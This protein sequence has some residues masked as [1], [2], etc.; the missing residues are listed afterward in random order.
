MVDQNSQFYAILTNVGA[1]KQA[2]ADVLG[3]PWKITQMGVGDANGSDPTPNATQT[4]LINEWR[5][6]PL[7]QLK[8]D[9]KN[10]AIIVAE[11]V[12]PADVGGKW[13]REIALYDADGDMIAVAN[14]APTYKPLLSQG[15]GR[16][17]VVRMSL[18]VSSSSNVQLK[19]DPSV[20]LS[21]R[22]FV[23]E[24]LARQDFKHSVLVA[25]TASITLSGLQTVD[26]VPLPA[27]ARVLVKNQVAAKD[28]GLFTVVAS[29]PWTRCVDADNSAKVTS[30]LFVL[31]EKGTANGDS[32]WQLV[33]DDPINVGVTPLAFE[34]A[35][36]RTGVAAG[37]YRSVQV[38]KYGRV[39][40]A[41]N[42]TTVAGYGLTDVFTKS[43]T[44]N[45][46]EIAQAISTAVSA[47]IDSAPG[48]LD[49]LKELA[50]ALGNDPN[51]ATTMLN[52]LA[53]KA[54]LSGAAFTGSIATTGSLTVGTSLELGRTD[55]VASVA[56][57][58]LH[59]GATPTDYDARIS[60]FGGNGTAG[61]GDITFTGK[62]LSFA[63]L[64]TAPAHLVNKAALDSAVASRAPL[65]SPT[66]MGT[67]SGPTPSAGA[68]NKLF[69]TTEFVQLVV[70]ALI[71]SAPAA[72]NTLKKLAAALGNDP[73]FAATMSTALASKAN[74]ATTLAGYGITDAYTPSTAT[75]AVAGLI[76]LATLANMNA[77]DSDGVAVTPYKLLKGLSLI[78]AGIGALKLPDWLGG[79][80]FQWGNVAPVPAAGVS[81][82]FPTTFPNAPFGVFPAIITPAPDDYEIMVSNVAQQGFVLR[83]YAVQIPNAYWFALGY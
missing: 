78:K 61:G 63:Q 80:I 13:I 35:F 64:P 14:C 42:P 26:G 65:D 53:Q 17:Q 24:E 31:V 66:F 7:N 75:E 46:A 74:K 71:D 77:G 32:A 20:V 70:A 73:N 3:I 51:F 21:T 15:S 23:T 36:G 40:A 60:A 28:N 62:S 16:T 54:N 72:L 4:S 49:T 25:T 69:A 58:D 19:I 11:Q 67:V 48:A 30:G 22:E 56:Y 33:T 9:D 41:T 43:E 29:G 82:S 38:D 6:A 12:I 10:S 47:L 39:V 5:R 45:R 55:G 2:N 37:T 8:V 27:G 59:C 44:Y 79:L 1:A 76:K 57:I 18:V 68:N 52:A 81:I 83:S 34:M 50:A